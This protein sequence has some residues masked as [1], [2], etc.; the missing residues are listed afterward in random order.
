M[1]R[2]AFWRE[3]ERTGKLPKNQNNLRLGEMPGSHMRQRTW[4]FSC[5]LLQPNSRGLCQHYIYC[6]GFGPFSRRGF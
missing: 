6:N 3:S 5:A 1:E 4:R 2:A